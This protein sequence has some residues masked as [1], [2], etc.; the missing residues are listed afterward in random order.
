M[1]ASLLCAHRM[2]TF[3]FHIILKIGG[4]IL[5]TDDIQ[6]TLHLF[7]WLCFD[8]K[9]LFLGIFRERKLVCLCSGSLFNCLMPFKCPVVY[10]GT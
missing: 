3:P 8:G 2:V 6:R 7:L 9:S 10:K 4:N 1:L 5:Y